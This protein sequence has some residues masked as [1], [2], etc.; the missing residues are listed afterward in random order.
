MFEIIRYRGSKGI[1]SWSVSQKGFSTIEEAIKGV[2][3]CQAFQKQ[4]YKYLICE[5]GKKLARFFENNVDNLPQVCYTKIK[6]K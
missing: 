6:R 1:Y 3:L 2:R 5:E 4:E